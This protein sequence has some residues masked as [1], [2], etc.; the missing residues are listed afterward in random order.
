MFMVPYILVI[1][2]VGMI[3]HLDIQGFIRILYSSI[4]LTLHDGGANCA[5]PQEHKLQ[6]T[7][8]GVCNLWKVK[9]T[10]CIKR[11]DFFPNEFVGR[12]VLINQYFGCFA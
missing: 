12:C 9:I 3:F 4:F 2:Y 11:C 1:I 10:N 7:A 5:Y 6:S 8:L